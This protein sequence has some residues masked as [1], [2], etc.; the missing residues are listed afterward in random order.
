MKFYP[1]VT[2]QILHFVVPVLILG[3]VSLGGIVAAAAAGLAMGLIRET[4]EGV[5]RMTWES[6]TTQLAKRDSQ[7]DLAFWALGG[8][9]AGVVL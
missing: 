2:D 6:V 3:L 4:A 9:F 1:H 7:I 8:A 5:R